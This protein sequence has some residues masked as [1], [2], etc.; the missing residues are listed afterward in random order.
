MF[1]KFEKGWKF[2]KK[3]EILEAVFFSFYENL[4]I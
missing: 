2:L 3:L 4:E 1:G